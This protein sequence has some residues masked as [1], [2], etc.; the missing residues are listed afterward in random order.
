MGITLWRLCEKLPSADPCCFNKS[1]CL[2]VVSA[3][4]GGMLRR[5]VAAESRGKMEYGGESKENEQ[6]ARYMSSLSIH[7][8]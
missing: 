7:R 2:L 1:H 5:A 3:S 4:V 6:A 8:A